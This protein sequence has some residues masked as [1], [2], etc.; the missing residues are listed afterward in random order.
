M[1]SVK[2]TVFFVVLI[3]DVLMLPSCA[4]YTLSPTNLTPCIIM[5]GEFAR[6]HRTYENES[7]MP[8]D[9]QFFPFYFTVFEISTVIQSQIICMEKS[10]GVLQDV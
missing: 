9:F 1:F 5:M 2:R 7:K 4:Q 6:T 8:F 10:I 3:Y